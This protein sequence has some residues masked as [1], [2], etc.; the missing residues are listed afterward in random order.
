MAPVVEVK[1]GMRIYK[2]GKALLMYGNRMLL[3]K[4]TPSGFE[5]GHKEELGEWEVPGGRAEDG[6]NEEETLKRE[7]R[8]EV[9]IDAV[10]VKELIPFEF[11]PRD[12]VIIRGKCF[13][14]R[15][16]SDNVVLEG[17]GRRHNAYR[18]VTPDEALAYSMPDWLRRAITGLVEAKRA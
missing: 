10:V 6:E 5:L 1:D 7:I 4:N 12:D 16:L 18:W 8:E 2:S 3:L 17:S 13:L 11:S 9:G 15:A 14:C